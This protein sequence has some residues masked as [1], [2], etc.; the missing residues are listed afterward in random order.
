MV[1]CVS[2]CVCACDID[3]LQ[4]SKLFG[5]SLL[6]SNSIERP[7]AVERFQMDNGTEQFQLVFDDG[8]RSQFLE[9]GQLDDFS[10]CLSDST[11]PRPVKARKRTRSKRVS[12]SQRT[13]RR[14][15]EKNRQ[16]KRQE[17]D[18]AR[19]GARK[20]HP[21]MPLRTFDSPDNARLLHSSVDIDHDRALRDDSSNIDAFPAL[22]SGERIRESLQ[23]YRRMVSEPVVAQ[24]VCA[25]CAEL[26]FAIQMTTYYVGERTS[27]QNQPALPPALLQ[28]MKIKLVHNPIM[29]C[30]VPTLT[31]GTLMLLSVSTFV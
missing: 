23:A 28:S 31:G 21:G 29:P 25:V 16:Q 9:T 18:I 7:V 10:K 13:A 20:R 26:D 22:P 14:Q 17:R 12:V 5:I 1:L 19:S 2:V 30:H 4:V 6:D 15:K 11:A 24:C 27:D 8:S 3:V